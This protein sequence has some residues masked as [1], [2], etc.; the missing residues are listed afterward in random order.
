MFDVIAFGSATRDIFCRIKDLRLRESRETIT[1]KEICLPFDFK[2]QVEGFFVRSGGGG[3]NSAATFANQG[4]KV[5][6]CGMVGKDE[7]GEAIIKEL[8]ARKIDTK[9][10]RQ[11]KKAQTNRSV[12]INA[13]AWIRTILV[14]RGASD[15]LK[16]S[17]ISFDEFKAKW[18]YLAPFSGENLGLF[19]DLIDFAY[20]NKIKVA[21][22][23]G[24]SQLSLEK[25]K[26]EKIL[27]KVDVLLLNR[28]EA[29]FL[30]KIPYSEEENIFKE[31]DRLCP[32]IAVMTKGE[33]GVVVSDGKYLYRA[34]A[35]KI[36]NP[37]DPTGAGDAFGS[38]FV[39]GLIKTGDIEYAI[40]L[41]MANSGLC[42]TGWGAKEG[43][44][45][46][47]RSFKKTNVEKIACGGNNGI[48][49]NKT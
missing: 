28:E 3:T 34:P 38:G 43:L 29:S 33:E 41:A 9:F 44:L 20:K 47:G 12:I 4:L 22:N 7:D 35:L 15:L 42:L 46:A 36:E 24:I 14:Y 32:G 45:K 17:E 27:K 25:E 21:L 18:F 8:R 23:P 48:C 2:V 26:L 49:L 5:A 13:S 31:I 19:A 37:I 1:G 10:I 11:T 16:K 6:Y 39:A 40:Q 30:T